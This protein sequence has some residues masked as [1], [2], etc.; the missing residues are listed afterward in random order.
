MK[1]NRARL[2]SLIIAVLLFGSVVTSCGDPLPD[3]TVAESQEV[4][5]ISTDE[6]TDISSDEITDTSSDESSGAESE[7]LDSESDSTPADEETA[8][9]ETED[10]VCETEAVTEEDTT[11]LL[12]GEYA[13]HIE[14]AERYANTVNSYFGD[15]SRADFVMENKNVSVIYDLESDGAKQIA[16]IQNKR[17]GTYVENTMDVFI[18]MS[19]GKT[20]YASDSLSD[21]KANIY[22]LGYYYYENSISGQSFAEDYVIEA[23]KRINFFN[24]QKYN[25]TEPVTTE[26]DELTIRV[27]DNSDPWFSFA[28]VRADTSDVNCILITMKADSSFYGKMTLYLIAGD[29]EGFSNNQ[30]TSFRVETDNEYHTYLIPIDRINDYNGKI[31]GM[32][33]DC[34]TFRGAIDATLSIKELKLVRASFED[35][36]PSNVYIDREFG[37]Y[38]DKLHQTLRVA[39]KYK[40]EGVEGIGFK[41]EIAKDTVGVVIAKDK[42]G[43]HY[44]F[45]EVD[46]STLE[47]VGFDVLNAGIFGFI[48]PCD[49]SG[50]TIEVIEDEEYY[51]VIQTKAVIGNTL[52]PSEKGT[53]NA[54]DFL[55]GHRI[56][57]DCNHSFDNFVKQAEIERNPLG[58]DSFLIDSEAST[59]GEY[60]GYDPLRGSYILTMD[61]T[62]GFSSHY[63]LHNNRQYNITFTVS[64]KNEDRVIYVVANVRD[65]DGGALECSAVLSKD[66]MLLPIPLEVGKNFSDS[67][68]LYNLDDSRYSETI[69]PMIAKAEAELTYSIVNAYHKWGAHLVKQISFIEYSSPYYHLSTGIHESNCITP[70]YTTVAGNDLNTLPDHRAMSSP[71]WD[72]D[73]QHSYCGNHYFI[74]YTDADGNYCASENTRD[75]IGSYGPTYADITMDYLS[76]DGKMKIS[77]N[78]MEMPQTDENRAYYEMKYEVLEDISF[79]DFG[80]DFSFYTASSN[81]P[82][83]LYKQ[84]GYLNEDNECTVAP[85]AERGEVFKYVLGDRCPYFSF[86]N[87]PDYSYDNGYSN[88]SFMIL[89]SEFVIGGEPAKPDFLAVNRYGY[90]SLS[91]DLGE[92]TLKAGDTF[93]I[94]AIIMP[95][96]SEESDYSGDEPDINVRTVREN[97]LLS[98]AVATVDRHCEIIESAFLP[99]IRTTTGKSAEFTLSGGE[100]YIAVRVYGFDMLTVPVV[101]EK[102]DGEWKTVNLSS[103]Y[104]PDDMGYGYRYDGYMVHYDGDGTYSYSFVF[105]VDDGEPRQLR[106]KAYESFEGWG[107]LILEG[108]NK[109]IFNAEDLEIKAIKNPKLSK[110][111]LLEE[112]GESFV[113]FS[114]ASAEAYISVFGGN[115]LPTGQYMVLKYRVPANNPNKFVS[116][117]FYTSTVNESAKDNSDSYWTSNMVVSDGEW[118]VIAVDLSL[119]GKETFAKNENGEYVAK[120]LRFDVFNDQVSDDTYYDIAY[121]AFFSTLEDIYAANEDMDR[122]MLAKSNTEYVYIS[123]DMPAM[124][125]SLT[126]TQI[127]GKAS[128]ASNRFVSVDLSEDQSYVR[129]T[130][131]TGSE[132]TLLMLN[133]NK[134]PTGRYMVLKYRVQEEA[135]AQVRYWNFYSSTVNDSPTQSDSFTTDS[136]Q[137]IS[138]GEWHVI[139]FDLAAHKPQAFV[140]NDDGVYIAKYLRLDIFNYSVPE[141]TFY[142]IAFIGMSDDIETVL[143]NN[144]DVES[145]MLS[146]GQNEY[147]MI[148]TESGEEIA[149]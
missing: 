113:R 47:Y 65:G 4:T 77:Y 8:D 58:S 9:S 18:R 111:E 57:T 129:F 11:P 46:F 94:N 131:T 106:V 87:M 103:A 1:K 63:Y 135:A 49:G 23:E 101:E 74:Q 75:L 36:A 84:V 41:T 123:K 42:N 44:S 51:T 7:P 116:W 20:F 34:D 6:V 110:V 122:I 132:A 62:G 136:N 66:Q 25:K 54:N 60:V 55:M 50:G 16:S 12:E 146:N 126:A 32:R 3:E 89:D 71:V 70:Y 117:N 61:G 147:K 96:G 22:R 130:G 64:G 43:I 52:I 120:Y 78:H 118:Q 149:Q 15:A 138:D 48:L 119:F 27:T 85:A 141:N 133:D 37:M 39:A 104:T 98:P 26:N 108:T 33:I 144:S 82:T 83:G 95:W 24:V 90:L 92:V 40:T 2:A 128:Q 91:L 81:D 121:I 97:S 142:D 148:S 53:D 28:N 72:T 102:T 17:G 125:V 10:S 112:D 107:E 68:S 100:N 30:S 88:L 115:E 134:S 31:T 19:S 76:D 109:F 124:N 127:Y 79:K 99:K 45:E 143:A 139:I 5:D 73:P 69:L 80:S 14:L 93:S 145:V 137:I 59:Y 21:A 13:E 86:F 67:T 38:S 105:P 140:A 56:Y 35:D 29:A 114:G